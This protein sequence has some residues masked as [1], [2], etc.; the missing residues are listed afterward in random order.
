MAVEGNIRLTNIE[1]EM[2]TSYLDY[3]MSVIVSRALPDARDGLKPVH[4]R[5]LFSMQDLN[6]V[7]NQPYRK[8]ARIVGDVLGKYHPH[9]D[10]SVY[11][12]MVRLAQDFSM[13]H[14][15]V[16]GQ[17]NF[18]SV[19]GDPPAA[20]RYTEV[21][22]TEFGEQ[23]LSDLDKETV[24]FMPNFDDSLKEPVV[25]PTK[26]PNLLINGSSGIAV[27]M[28]TNIPTHNLGE[29]CNAISFLIDNPEATTDELL[30]YVPGPDFPTGGIIIGKEG[31]RSAYAT[32]RGKIV[33]RAKA[34][35]DETASGRRQIIV[36]ELPYQV[37]KAE[38]IKKIAELVKDKKITGI[39]ELRDESDR[40]GMRIAIDLKRDAQPQHL[41]NQLYKHTPM[42]TGFGINMLALVKGQ[43]RVLTLKEALEC[44]IDFRHDVIVRRTNHEL[45]LAKDRAHVLE[46]LKIAL[47][48]LDA[49]IKTIR[50]SKSVDDA[51]TSLM[52]NYE[53]TKIQ[54][55]AILDMRLRALSSLERQA[56]IDEYEALLKTIA[57]LE[58]LVTNNARIL[59]LVK[60]EADETGAKFGNGRMTEISN[61]G[62]SDLNEE[63]LIP[64][65]SMV[66]TLSER[67]FIKRVATSTYAAQHRGGLGKTAMTTREEDHIR[68]LTEADTHDK[69]LFFTNRGRVFSVKCHEINQDLSRV[70]KGISIV[71]LIPLSDNEKV[72]AMVDV[73]D[74]TDTEYLVMATDGGEVKKVKL[75]DFS[76]IRTTGVIAYDLPKSDSLIS[77]AI[78]SDDD[79]VVMVSQH[80]QSICFDTKE[81]RTS[82]KS[83]GG[84]CGFKLSFGDRVISMSRVRPDGF[85][86]VVTSEGNGK[87]TPMNAYPRQHRAGLGVRTFHIK[88]KTGPLVDAQVVSKD[89]DVMLISA[90][91]VMT[92]TPVTEDNPKQ[93]ITIQGRSTQGVRVMTLNPG[94]Q[95][96]CITVIDGAIEEEAMQQAAAAA[97]PEEAP[98]P[99]VVEEK[100]KKATRKRKSEDK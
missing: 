80:G 84:V 57:D 1:H 88:D 33:I 19:D 20:M 59:G 77:A 90:N 54:A 89:S 87:I 61:E 46:G 67:G 11:D 39:A 31:I 100:P 45:K 40:Q 75:A 27:G 70:G 9:G 71:N 91:G 81:I 98:E 14:C 10:S 60:S 72:T 48:H 5:I 97:A 12:A 18:G 92:R 44:F 55:Q 86:M 47:D 73:K 82:L 15:L 58:D 79:E 78:V 76:K 3:A 43:P 50:E 56:I 51:R 53:L 23:M 30:E 16:D 6:V 96:A 28:A 62:S 64:H 83:S 42:Q 35:F 94:D 52:E 26:V 69:I 38:L 32:G 66:I 65:D 68:I 13:R 17:G 7:H 95:V 37:N 34:H 2:K 41:L 74:F 49:I 29:I 22:L 63:D 4:R 99:E 21:R 25:L 36:T 93:G 24:D 85:L 8:S